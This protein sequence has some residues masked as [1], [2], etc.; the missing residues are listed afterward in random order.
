MATDEEIAKGL[1]YGDDMLNDNPYAAPYVNPYT[2]PYNDPIGASDIP[3][4]KMD[5]IIPDP[6]YSPPKPYKPPKATPK[7]YDKQSKYS[8]KTYKPPTK[9][10]NPKY[11]KPSNAVH[12]SKYTPS[13]LDSDYDKAIEESLKDLE[14]INEVV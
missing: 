11:T 9:Q 8:H 6:H 3:D 2:D 14:Q 1:M 12:K 4:Y 5:Q 10:T 7:P 13:G